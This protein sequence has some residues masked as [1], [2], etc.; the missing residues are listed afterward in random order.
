MNVGTGVCLLTVAAAL[1]INLCRN[2]GTDVN[3]TLAQRRGERSGPS[4]AAE[5]LNV[6]DETVAINNTIW[7]QLPGRSL[8]VNGVSSRTTSILSWLWRREPCTPS[9]RVARSQSQ[10][11]GSV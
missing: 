1:N 9:T 10:Y 11:A 5:R 6:N 3:L 2:I 8:R 7:Y 4:R